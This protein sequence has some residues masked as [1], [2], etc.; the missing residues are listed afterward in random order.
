[1]RASAMLTGNAGGASP[2]SFTTVAGTAR[3]ALG[4][5]AAGTV[6]ITAA[7]FGAWVG[8]AFRCY[9]T[10]T[11]VTDEQEMQDRSYDYWRDVT[12]IN[13]NRN[14]R[15]RPYEISIA[16]DNSLCLGPVPAAGYT[17]TGDYYIAP[18]A[19]AADGDEPT[20]LPLQYHMAIVYRAM[21][22]YGSREG[23]P[24]VTQRGALGYDRLMRELEREWMPIITTCGPIA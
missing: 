3:Y 13:A 12:F 10:A 22:D 21:V 11:G 4:A 17:I 23:A 1:M 7:T 18:T 5:P 2:L 20:G 14:V 16:P 9:L 24:E 19:M 15:S 6:G 8:G